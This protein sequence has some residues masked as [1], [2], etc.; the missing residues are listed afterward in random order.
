MWALSATMAEDWPL[1]DSAYRRLLEK[2]PEDPLGWLGLAG[3]ARRTGDRATLERALATLRSYPA[4]GEEM[5]IIRRH[6]LYYPQ[7]W[8]PPD[9]VDGWSPR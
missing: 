9:S 5:T 7:V 8:P 6:L 2:A 1:A 4:Q 3:I